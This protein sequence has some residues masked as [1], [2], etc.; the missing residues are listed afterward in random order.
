MTTSYLDRGEG[1]IAYDV[2]GA[3]PLVIC[4]PGMGDLRTVYR[5]TVPALVE[6]GFRVAT[7][8]L[9]GHGDSATTFGAYDDLAAA[10]DALALAEHLG[11]SAVIVGNS[12]G[13]GAAVIVAAQRPDLIA[14]IVL[15][16]PFVRNPASNPLLSLA[17][18]LL[19]TRPWGPAAMRAF[20]RRSY[21]GRPPADLDEHIG[22]IRQSLRRGR[23]WRSFVRT[24]R[25]D[26]T[27]ARDRLDQ[28]RS[29]ALVV[30]GTKDA[31][32]RDPVAE[33]RFVADALRAELVLVPDAGH[34]P[35]AEYPEVV[36]PALIAF[37]R[38]V[39]TRA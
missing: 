39:S 23:N 19:L 2:R 35:M 38:R 9:R 32:W 33:A 29:P 6:A 34:Y 25:T 14:G 3:G 12:M 15:I 13:A 11:G 18:R 27:P 28:V 20:Y 26:H 1:R 24:T 36:N 5:F 21:P 4:L 37:A 8:D 17:F 7:M 22:R 10:S 31:D 16:G 30:M